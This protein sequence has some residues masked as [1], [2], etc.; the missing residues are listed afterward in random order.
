MNFVQ[1]D[2]MLHIGSRYREGLTIAEWN[3]YT[4]NVV[5]PGDRTSTKEDHIINR[6]IVV[7]QNGSVG[8]DTALVAFIETEVV[9]IEDGVDEGCIELPYKRM[10]SMPF[11]H[12]VRVRKQVLR[13]IRENAWID[14]C[15][16]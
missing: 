11:P 3:S 1:G 16:T 13:Q 10:Y 15:M 4:G 9:A 12:D 8:Q 2:T 5:Y 7:A 6:L 14:L